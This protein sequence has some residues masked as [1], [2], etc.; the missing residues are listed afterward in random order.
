MVSLWRE[1]LPSSILRN[2]A[3][4]PFSTEY[5]CRG[6]FRAFNRVDDAGASNFVQSDLSEL[7]TIANVI[8]GLIELLW[9]RHCLASINAGTVPLAVAADIT[10]AAR[11]VVEIASELANSPAAVLYIVEPFDPDHL[12]RASERG[13]RRRHVELERFRIK[14]SISGEV[15]TTGKTRVIRDLLNE[16]GVANISVAREEKFVSAVVVPVVAQQMKGCL[17]V[18]SRDPR[19]YHRSTVQALENLG[20]LAANMLDARARSRVVEELTLSL[21]NAGHSARGPARRIAAALD[22]IRTIARQKGLQASIESLISSTFDEIELLDNRLDSFLL[23]SPDSTAAMGLETRIENLATLIDRTTR[24]YAAEANEAGIRVHIEETVGR[25]PPIMMDPDKIELALDNLLENAI[26][27]SW[28]NEVITIKAEAT[29][30][31]VCIGVSDKGLGIPEALRD[32]IFDPTMRSNV[33]DQTRY[34]PGT[35]LGLKIVKNIIDAHGGTIRVESKPFLN[36]P[37]RLSKYEG[38]LTTF[39]IVLPRQG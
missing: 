13:L 34:I 22:E 19:E 15:V 26:K 4:I 6:V 37:G 9:E 20:A 1:R 11:Q 16:R 36:D 28:R 23:A 25:L 31:N 7:S 18:F 5:E 29:T 33:L 14:D 17:V 35:G 10:S 27:Y 8:A 3:F 38:F 12:R 2:A 30:H 32:A 21:E 24:R 39:W